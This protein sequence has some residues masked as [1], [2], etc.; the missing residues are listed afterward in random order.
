MKK[1]KHY[2]KEIIFFIVTMTI[3]ANLMSIY[4]S[5][6]LT[7]ESLH[8]NSFE[9]I[10]KS[11][12]NV[13]PNKPL[14]IHFWATWCPTCKLEASNIEFLSKYFEV[15]TIAVKSGSDEDIKKYLKE[16]DYHFKV[17]N[18]SN[19]IVTNEFHVAGFPTTFIYDKKH[20]LRF[21]EVG[22]TSTLGLYL[23]M[24]WADYDPTPP[25]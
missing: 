8:I 12:Y 17:F 23:R 22:Y 11:I 2:I 19:G 3:V 18:D 16:H 1:I 4:R 6:D 15:I 21:S 13:K 14:L 24:L 7:K 25:K 5:Q 10:D 9:L 20:N